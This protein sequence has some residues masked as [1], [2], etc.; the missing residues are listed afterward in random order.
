VSLA[1]YL[2]ARV[3]T[4]LGAIPVDDGDP[5]AA[6]RHVA[7]YGDSGVYTAGDVTHTSDLVTFRFQLTYIVE[8]PGADRPQCDWLASKARAALID[9]VPTVAG[10]QLAPV[11][12]ET[13][14]AA[15]PDPDSTTSAVFSVDKFVVR[16][17]RA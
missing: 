3:Q 2:I 11:E 9:H 6:P 15:K 10:F 17:S 12:H 16:G 7:F 13:A 4:A 14:L 1:D 5:K 8:G